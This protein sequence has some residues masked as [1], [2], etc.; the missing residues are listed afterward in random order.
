[1][2]LKSMTAEQLFDCLVQA[3]GFE[4]A[5]RQRR[6]TLVLGENSTKIAFL[7]KF[8][9]TGPSRTDYQASILQA[10]TLMNGKLIATA[11]SLVDSQTLGAVIE[12][13]FLDTTQRIETLF[14]ASLSRY[15][16]PDELAEMRQYVERSATG[17][18]RARSLADV[19]WALLNSTEFALVH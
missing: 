18:E 5:T 13:P 1:M 3:T 10:L 9:D 12:A 15:P 19:F 8:S 16:T 14:L 11:T 4:E 17:A 7:N 2:P 6:D